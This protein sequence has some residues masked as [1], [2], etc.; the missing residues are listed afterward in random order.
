MRQG[1]KNSLSLCKWYHMAT[2]PNSKA[3]I[4]LDSSVVYLPFLRPQPSYPPELSVRSLPRQAC[5]NF[6][7]F[8][9][10]DSMS[11]AGPS[12]LRHLARAMG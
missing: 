8:L 4:D 2:H 12:K 3:E 10:R 6:F 5:P 1:R 7:C 11:T 9:A